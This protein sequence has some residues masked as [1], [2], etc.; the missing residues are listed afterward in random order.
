MRGPQLAGSTHKAGSGEFKTTVNV[1]TDLSD[2]K[3]MMRVVWYYSQSSIPQVT[4]E[5]D[6]TVLSR[7][8]FKFWKCRLL[9]KHN[10]LY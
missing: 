5:N 10:G 6:S 9:E 8:S 3:M 4:T 7:E 1:D 2:T